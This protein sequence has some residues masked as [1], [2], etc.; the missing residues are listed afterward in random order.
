[1]GSIGLDVDLDFC[2]VAISDRGARSDGRIAT[3]PEQLELFA[4]SLAPTDRVV[5][6]ATGNGLVIA[7][8][9]RPLVAD[10]VLAH[11]KQVRAI[12]HARVKTD[13]IDAKVRADLLAADL[14]PTV[15]I[16]DDRRGCCVDWWRAG[17]GWSSA[18]RRSRTRSGSVR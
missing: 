13:K 3:T 2:Q 17:A 1:V 8:I 4:Q 12:S 10:V 9:L 7:R 15:W 16:G 5:V 14:I 18:A 6:E 11:A